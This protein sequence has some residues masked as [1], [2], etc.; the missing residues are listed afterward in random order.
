[1]NNDSENWNGDRAINILIALILGA[2]V[3]RAVGTL[4]P[5]E[6]PLRWL[7]LSLIGV[8]SL[9]LGLSFWPPVNSR[10]N[11]R[12]YFV[13]QSALTLTLLLLPPHSDF[14]AVFFGILSVQTIRVFPRN[15]AFR[16]IAAFSLLTGVALIIGLGW[17]DAMPFIVLYT[18]LNFSLAYFVV[19]KKQAESTQQKSQILLEE[20]QQTHRQLQEHATQ[21]E[22]L[23]VMKERN[24]LARDL[25]DSVT[26]S[27]YSLTLFTQAARERADVGDLKQTNRSL[28]RIAET[29]GQALKEMRL[30]VYE[31]RP[32]ALENETL[33]EVL[34]QRLDLV[35]R[36]SGV[37]TRLQVEGEINLPDNIEDELY[38]IGQEALNNAL[39][40]AQATSVTVRLSQSAD[41][42]ALRF[43]VMDDGCGFD[44]EATEGGAGLGLLSMRERVENLGG[45]LEIS[46]APGQGTRVTV[47]LEME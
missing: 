23:A 17:I 40:H 28:A 41:N 19:L 16:W 4:F 35:E 7:A 27:L 21:I 20:L 30:L 10:L 6:D 42:H 43:Q 24:R 14:Y 9:L 2:V 18:A 12:L 15:I 29:A 13:V 1:M 39:K 36:R 34:Q 37:Q 32:L 46:S 5:N 38:H 3:L 45:S 31:L 33:V 25:H 47:D 11:P 22:E 44:P 26:Q 8:F